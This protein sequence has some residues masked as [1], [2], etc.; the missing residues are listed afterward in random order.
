MSTLL[1]KEINY[2]TFFGLFS[3]KL[4][5]NP[6]SITNGMATLKFSEIDKIKYQVTHHILAG[7]T[8]YI[9]LHAAFQ[10]KAGQMISVDFK[11]EPILFGVAKAQQA[12]DAIMPVIQQL[13]SA[14]VQNG[15]AVLE[16]GNR[17]DWGYMGISKEGLDL[18]KVKSGQSPQFLSWADANVTGGTKQWVLVGKKGQEDSIG[19]YELA[20]D[21]NAVCIMPLLENAGLIESRNTAQS[22][23]QKKNIGVH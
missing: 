3:K 2:R 22:P 10:D 1:P 21:W 15:K 23:H 19:R 16:S 13:H 6:D 7:K 4:I 18:K 20:Q 11:S 17:V 12:I 5:V 14:I 8:K 9:S